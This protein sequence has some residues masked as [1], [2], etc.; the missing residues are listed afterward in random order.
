[1]TEQVNDPNDLS[2]PAVLQS[3]DAKPGFVVPPVA[4]PVSAPAAQLPAG[5]TPEALAA[6]LA[7]LEAQKTPVAPV[8][9]VQP[10][11]AT[12]IDP[13]SIDDPALSGM[14]GIFLDSCEGIDI[15]RVLGKAIQ[16]GN[17][18]DIDAAYLKDIGKDRAPHLEK[19]AGAIVQAIK[20]GAEASTKA[21]YAEAGSEAN[22]NAAAAAFN[23][24]A[25]EHLK[26]VIGQMLQSSSASVHQSAAKMVV[27]FAQQ[28]GFVNKEATLLKGG[29]I[30]VGGDAL[31]TA[32]FKA[33]IGKLDTYSSTYASDVQALIQRRKLGKSLNQN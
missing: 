7:H 31:D 18:A 30:H 19:L 20:A 9:P 8:V 13:A 6:A 27:Q 22:W 23:Q 11:Q 12:S 24:S 16:S 32:G 5:V 29:G 1:M 3:A 21:A 25:P 2:K 33:A 15:D 14:L 28:G 10:V 4:A 26:A 17:P